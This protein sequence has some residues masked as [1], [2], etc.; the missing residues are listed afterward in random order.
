MD[1]FFAGHTH[2]LQYTNWNYAND[3]KYRKPKTEGSA[4]KK[5]YEMNPSGET[6]LH[7][8]KGEYLHHFIVGASGKHKLE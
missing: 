3:L 7:F 6:K 5:D 1:F 2:T 8:N 4:C